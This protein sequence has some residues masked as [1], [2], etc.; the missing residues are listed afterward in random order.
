MGV[1]CRA[2]S[3][4]HDFLKENGCLFEQW[5]VDE[6]CTVLLRTLHVGSWF[7]V[8]LTSAVKYG[9]G[10]R[11]GCKAGSTMFNGAYDILLAVIKSTLEADG[12]ALNLTSVGDSCMSPSG[13]SDE[14]VTVLDSA[15]IDDVSI[16]DPCTFC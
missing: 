8:G 13:K 6:L 16:C 4:I 2:A 15:F 10:G 7:S 11:Q 3:H 1:S 9:L 14:T 12:L 5:G